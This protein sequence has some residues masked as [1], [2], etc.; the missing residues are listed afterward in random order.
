MVDDFQFALGTALFYSIDIIG[1]NNTTT[2]LEN[3]F[4]KS[5]LFCHKIDKQNTF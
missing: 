2:I 3:N 1:K 5:A 4:L